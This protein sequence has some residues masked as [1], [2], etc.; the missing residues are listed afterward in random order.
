MTGLT[1]DEARAREQALMMAFGILG[2]ANLIN[3]IAS[4]NWNDPRFAAEVLQMR[5]LFS[6]IP[7][8]D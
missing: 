8:T 3:S 7:C 5:T 1:R 2:R 6:T 4:R